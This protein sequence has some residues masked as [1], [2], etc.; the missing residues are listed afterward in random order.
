MD[1]G[2]Q[3]INKTNKYSMKKVIVLFGIILSNFET[4]CQAQV[5]DSLFLHY[6]QYK[7]GKNA[8]KSFKFKK[9]DLIRE[10]LHQAATQIILGCC[11]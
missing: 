11:R 3:K 7:N 1:I 10:Y 9:K 2:F 6:Y 4:Y 5:F 8:P